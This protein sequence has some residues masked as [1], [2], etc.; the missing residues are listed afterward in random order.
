VLKLSSTY[1]LIFKQ[2][3]TLHRLFTGKYQS[4]K[5]RYKPIYFALM[6][7]MQT[8]LPDEYLKM[9]EELVE[10]VNDLLVSIRKERERLSIS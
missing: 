4:L 3:Q 1:F 7:E 9:P 8:E 6:H 10:P 2:L 5:D